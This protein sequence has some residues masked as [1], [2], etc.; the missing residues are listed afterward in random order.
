MPRNR[1]KRAALEQH[2]AGNE[3]D[4]EKRGSGFQKKPFFTAPF[5]VAYFSSGSGFLPSGQTSRA[6]PGSHHGENGKK[7]FRNTFFFFVTASLLDLCSFFP[8]ILR[9]ERLQTSI[10]ANVTAHKACERWFL[11]EP[12]LLSHE[13]SGYKSQIRLFKPLNSENGLSA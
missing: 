8:A 12:L 11:P 2:R 1:I 3:R 13:K 10:L 5:S 4:C 7:R 9:F 6:F